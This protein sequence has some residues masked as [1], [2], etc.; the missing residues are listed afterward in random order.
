MTCCADCDELLDAGSLI[1]ALG[2][3]DENGDNTCDRCGKKDEDAT[4]PSGGEDNPGSGN[5]GNDDN[6]PGEDNEGNEDTKPG[7]G[8]E[9]EDD[10]KEETIWDII[11]SY[12]QS[13]I[14][15]IMEAL[16]GLFDR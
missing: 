1:P 4:P 11:M 5:T 8:N 15:S 9:G 13:I 2:H 6:K 14:D 16:S 3:I 10:S 7:S 12:I